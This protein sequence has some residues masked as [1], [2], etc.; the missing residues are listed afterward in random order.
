MLIMQ[1]IIDSIGELQTTF[2][3]IK[4]LETGT[5]RSFTEKHESTKHIAKKLGKNGDLVSIDT[6][7]KAIEIS[8]KIC[9]KYNNIKWINSN[10]IDYL[11]SLNDETYHFVLLDSANNPEIIW[12]EFK[13]IAPR[14]VT[15]GILMVDDAGI[16]KNGKRDSTGAK[17]GY[18][19]WDKLGDTLVK[20]VS[21][22]HGT[23]LKIVFNKENKIRIMEKL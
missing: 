4:A 10:S 20:I 8:K 13:L 21:S 11:K 22:P 18:L 7:P 6:S 15:N 19:V 1:K 9:D 14:M 23:Q 2:S 16:A 17:K 3:Y 12:N 5:I